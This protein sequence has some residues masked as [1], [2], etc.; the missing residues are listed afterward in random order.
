MASR[1]REVDDFLEVFPNSQVL[2][3]DRSSI[4]LPIEVS[5]GQRTF[6]RIDLGPSFPEEEPKLSVTHPVGISFLDRNGFVSKPDL[7]W[8]KGISRLTSFVSDCLESLRLSTYDPNSISHSGRE[9]NVKLP[10]SHGFQ[11]SS[12]VSSSNGPS[13]LTNAGTAS[14]STSNSTSSNG[15]TS[16]FMNRTNNPYSNNANITNASNSSNKNLASNNDS[17][18]PRCP[19]FPPPP[20]P[21]PPLPSN[22]ISP[23]A[24][25][26]PN[27]QPSTTPPALSELPRMS[28]SLFQSLSSLEA[29]LNHESVSTLFALLDSPSDFELR[30]ESL[31]NQSPTLHSLHEIQS[32]NQRLAER[33]LDLE[34]KVEQAKAHVAIVKAG[35]FAVAKGEFEALKQRYDAVV[36]QL[37]PRALLKAIDKEIEEM[38]KAS[39]D[40]ALKFQMSSNRAHGA[41]LKTAGVS[42]VGGAVAS[43]AEMTLDQFTDRYLQIR[44]KYHAT[45]LKRQAAAAHFA[46][47]GI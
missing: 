27:F 32:R 16:Y 45:D 13:P 12:T 4:N 38:D 22:I 10:S 44:M 5:G 41:G 8:R 34:G 9:D 17:S 1:N 37:H 11:A 25:H 42:S 43:A 28:A 31:L 3:N 24:M 29:S 36:E 35:D 20:P 46:Q 26:S 33:N 18:P 23:S 47:C 30:L 40:L 14:L 7:V 39:D 19:P 15:Y 6:L 2:N 21:P